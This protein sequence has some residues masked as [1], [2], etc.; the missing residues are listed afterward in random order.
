[1]RCN[2]EI[3][4]G[5]KPVKKTKFKCFLWL[6]QNHAEAPHAY[7]YID[8]PDEYQYFSRLVKEQL[9]VIN[10]SIKI[11]DFGKTR[12]PFQIHVFKGAYF[13]KAKSTYV[14]E[15]WFEAFVEYHFPKY[16]FS[17]TYFSAGIQKET[18]KFYISDSELLKSDIS[19]IRHYSGEITRGVLSNITIS[20]EVGHLGIKSISTDRYIGNYASNIL[21]IIP[22]S[23]INSVVGFYKKIKPIAEFILLIT[24]CAERRRLNWHKSDSPIEGNLVEIYD[25]RAVFRDDKGG[26]LLISRF[27]FQDYLKKCLSN[28]DSHSISHISKVLR[29]YLSGME[30]SPNAKII[31]WNSIL[32]RS[33]KEKVDKKNDKLKETLIQQMNIYTA[34]LPPIQRLIDIRNAVA[35]GDEILFEDIVTLQGKWQILIERIILKELDWHDLSMTDVNVN[36]LKPIGL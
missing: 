9:R 17:K 34:D 28:I 1:M 10:I 21:E 11:Y 5:N 13:S 18:V 35:H 30:Y 36:A 20:E 27:A 2:A 16:A 25:T 24:S 32:E 15:N 8:S 4:V 7:L 33:L 6:P 3:F 31:L 29:S 19:T 14:S 22:K 12:K 23:S 26:I